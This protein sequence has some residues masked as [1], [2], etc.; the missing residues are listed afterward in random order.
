[1]I[2]GNKTSFEVM[3]LMKELSILRG[4][5]MN[6]LFLRKGYDLHPFEDIGSL[7]TMANKQNCH[8]FAVGT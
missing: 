8:L 2:K 3:Q 1:M 6:K 7:E 4:P 5:E